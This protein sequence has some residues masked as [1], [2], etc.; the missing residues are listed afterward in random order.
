M[1]IQ[2]TTTGRLLTTE[3]FATLLQLNPQ[4]LRKRLSQTGSYFGA[5]PVKLPN[6]RL[7]WPADSLERL[8]R[9]VSEE[10]ELSEVLK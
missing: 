6:G 3:Q 2:Q 4:T 9:P 8:L 10:Q 7:L 1:S 5:R